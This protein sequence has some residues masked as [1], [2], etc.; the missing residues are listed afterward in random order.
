MWAHF[1]IDWPKKA[2]KIINT[3]ESWTDKTITDKT[4]Q[5]FLNKHKYYNKTKVYA[6]QAK[7]YEI[8]MQPLKLK[9][10]RLGTSIVKKRRQPSYHYFCH[11]SS[12][13][14]HGQENHNSAPWTQFTYTFESKY[15]RHL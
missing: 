9:N 10:F 4:Y 14:Q 7:F 11:D 12:K 5:F 1:R 2:L 3:R 6:Y 13:L 8:K 15:Q